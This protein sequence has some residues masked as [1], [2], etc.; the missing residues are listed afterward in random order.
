MKIAE[1]LLK[2]IKTC[3]ISRYKISADTG[4]EQSALSRFVNGKRTID[5]ETAEKLCDYFGLEL[6]KKKTQK[7]R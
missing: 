2:T 5:L 7:G 6:A 4:I 1:L 3:G